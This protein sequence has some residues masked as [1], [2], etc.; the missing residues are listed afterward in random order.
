MSLAQKFAVKSMM[1][2]LSSVMSLV[3]L[4]FM[5]RYVGAEYGEMMMWLSTIGLINLVTDLGFN[6]ACVKSI[7]EKK[8]LN[9]CISTFAFLK[10]TMILVLIAIV[11][12]YMGISMCTRDVDTTEMYII[13]IFLAY[14]ILYDITWIMICSFDGL[15]DVKHSSLIQISEV[16]VRSTFLAIFAWMQVSADVLST[17]YLIGIVFALIVASVFF[18]GLKFKYVK[19]KFVKEFIAF[20]KPVAIGITMVA[21]LTFVDRTIIGMYCGTQDVGYYSAASGAAYALTMIGL[22]INNVI[23]PKF[24]DQNANN[25]HESQK[26]TLWN[27]QKYVSLFLI[28]VLIVVAVFG[29]DI[30]RVFLGEGYLP[31][32]LVLSIMSVYIYAYIMVGIESQLFYSTNKLESYRRMSIVF[33][34]LTIILLFVTVPESLFG[35]PMFGLGINGAAISIS[36]GYGVF[37]LMLVTSAH[38]QLKMALYPA[39]YKQ[40]IATVVVAACLYLLRENVLGSAGLIMLVVVT[41][42]CFALYFVVLFILRDIKKSDIG[43]IKTIFTKGE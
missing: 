4:M 23:L 12:A 19:P 35:I 29:T 6:S 26:M 13:L 18:R 24:S 28:P 38:S 40:F 30:V 2:I 16:L 32:G 9:D 36:I 1:S 14:Y 17:G 31:A 43:L 39:I 33:A 8:D 3:S 11:G 20:M 41:V 10:C 5:S 25:D 27:L 37:L 21:A 34:A 15:M 22:A 42:L 7:G